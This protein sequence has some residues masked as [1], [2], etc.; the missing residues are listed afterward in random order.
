MRLLCFFV[1][2][3][4]ICHAELFKWGDLLPRRAKL[5]VLFIT[6]HDAVCPDARS[7]ELPFFTLTFGRFD[8]VMARDGRVSLVFEACA[9]PNRPPIEELASLL[10][11]LLRALQYEDGSP[12][13]EIDVVAHSMGGLVLRSYL[14]GRALTPG[15]APKVRKAVFIATPHF[16][17]SV[18]SPLE[19][20]PQLREMA[21]G[22]RFL[23]DLATWNQGRDDLAGVDAL[24]IVGSAGTNGEPGFTDSVVTLTSA[25]LAFAT[26][27]SSDRT[28]ILPLCHTFGGIGALLLCGGAIGLARVEDERHPTAQAVVSFLNGTAAWQTTGVPAKGNFLLSGSAGV[29][30]QLRDAHDRDLPIRTASVITANGRSVPLNVSIAGL[31]YADKLPPG[32]AQLSLN[33]YTE[34]VVLRGGGGQALVSKPGPY[35]HAVEPAFGPVWPL[36]LAPGMQVRVKGMRFGLNPRVSVWGVPVQVNTLPTG[37]LE[38]VLPA[39]LKGG[40]AEVSVSSDAGRHTTQIYVQPPGRRNRPWR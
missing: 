26:D 17:T 32:P 27:F 37:E 30:V 18:A 21:P 31:A 2:L 10:T 1:L 8:E 12:V 25:S 29:L 16:G 5:P 13:T 20:D 6:G 14:Y 38:L 23:F 39:T 22:S 11:R 40:I 19:K 9:T 15:G 34:T 28:I 3:A 4:G 36:V 7:G 35:I 24:S 33:G